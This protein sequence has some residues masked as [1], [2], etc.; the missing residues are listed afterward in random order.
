MV[1]KILIGAI[2]FRVEMLLTIADL[3]ADSDKISFSQVSLRLCQNS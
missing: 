1:G 2:D 3:P